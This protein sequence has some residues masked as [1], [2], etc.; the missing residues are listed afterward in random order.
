RTRPPPPETPT[1]PDRPFRAADGCRR[2]DV[3]LACSYAYA[4]WL[5]IGLSV[6][7]SVGGGDVVCHSSPVASHGFWDAT[8]PYHKDQTR[9]ASGTTYLT[10]SS[11]AP[12]VDI[13]FR[14]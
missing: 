4:S 14:T 2:T 6:K 8:S 12:A 10:A 1:C 11:E 3:Q 7:F 5:T 13:R 9:L